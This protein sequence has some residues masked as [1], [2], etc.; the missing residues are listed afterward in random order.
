MPGY[1]EDPSEPTGVHTS[2]PNRKVYLSKEQ[3]SGAYRAISPSNTA[4]LIEP[5]GGIYVGAGGTIKCRP[6]DAKGDDSTA[7]TFVGVPTGTILPIRTDKIFAT[8][9]TAASLVALY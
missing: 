1:R 2:D 5:T 6:A 9:T 8:G 3:Y 4:D 7:V